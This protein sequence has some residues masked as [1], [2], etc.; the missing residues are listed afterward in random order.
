MAP[1]ACRPQELPTSSS[2]AM[3]SG[4]PAAQGG[5]QC[6][7]HVHSAC[8]LSCWCHV[9]S[10]CT[11]AEAGQQRGGPSTLQHRAGRSRQHALPFSC[12]ALPTDVVHACVEGREDAGHACKPMGGPETSCASEPA[13][14]GPLGSHRHSAQFSTAVLVL[15]APTKVG[16]LHIASSVQQDVLGLQVAVHCAERGWEEGEAGQDGTGCS[17]ASAAEEKPSQQQS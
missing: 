8:T 4:V 15:S 14:T 6:M 17:S 7:L 2:G 9:R 11:A 16:D 1:S 10:H 13:A 12:C 5:A 3:K